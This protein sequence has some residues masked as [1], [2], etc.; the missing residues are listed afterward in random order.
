MP[1]TSRETVASDT[2]SFEVEPIAIIGLACRPPGARDARQ[3]W[4]NLVQGVESVRMETLEEQ[5]ARGVPEAMLRDPNFVP[6]VALV[7]DYEYF[8]AG[9]FGMSAREAQI[10][11]PQHRMFLELSYTA[12]E[13]AG[14]DPFRYPGDIGVYAGCGDAS[15]E[16]QHARR[17]RKVLAGAGNL[18]ISLGT[19]P[20]FLATFISYKLD[21]RGPS[22]TVHT[23]CSTSLVTLHL[24]CEALRN[25]ECDMA[26]S[27]AVSID[28]P[29]GHGYIYVD[30]GIYSPD[31]HVRAF[32]AAARGTI[33]GNGGGMVLLK[34]LC[35]ALAD[36]DHI[37]ALVR[38]NA[39]NN[40]GSA[41][42]G[43]TAPS[44]QAQAVV[45]AQALG[46]ADVDPR[47]ISY[48]EAHGTGTQLG[49]PI[50]IA[51]LT[52]AYGAGTDAVGWCAIGSVKPNVGHMG[53][54][55]GVISIIKTTLALEN[56]LIPPSVNYSAPNPAIDFP[57]TPFYVNS[58]L[59]A[60][61]SNGTPRRAGVSSF[62]MGG[63][64]AHVIMQE[65]PWT[66]RRKPP[67]T[68]TYLLP[69][70]ARSQS[71]LA[72]AAQDL[73]AR[74]S[75]AHVHAASSADDSAAFLDLADVS[76]TLRVGRREHSHRLAVVAS[77]LEQAAAA[78]RDQ[79]RWITAG[80]PAGTGSGR[81]PARLT[82]GKTPRVALMFSGQGAQY[83]GMGSQLYR[84]MPAFRDIVDECADLL[85]SECGLDLRTALL[86]DDAAAGEALKQTALA[87]PALFVIE[88]ALARLW[89]SWGIEP[90]AMIGHSIGEYVA[91]T[92]AGVFEL[93]DALRVVAAR[94]RLMQAIAP[95]AMLA[96]QLG[97]AELQPRLPEDVSI[98][99]INGPATCVVAGPHE[100][101]EA[102]ASQLAG[103]GVGSRPLRTSHAFHSSMMDPVLAEFRAVVADA[104]PRAPARPFVSNV[105]GM[106][107]SPR[108]AADPSFWARH[109]REPVRFG[110][111]LRTLLGDDDEWLLVECGPGR[112]LCGLA[113]LNRASGA[114]PVPSLPHR[115]DRSN[116]A[117]TI[118]AAAALLWASGVALDLPSFAAPGFRVPLPTYPWERKYFWID[119]DPGGSG[120]GMYDD[121]LEHAQERR[122]LPDWF[123]VPAWQQLPPGG[124]RRQPA[125]RVLLFA[126][127][128]AL[129]IA[130]ALTAAGADV[131]VVRPGAAFADEG[132]GRYTIRPQV[133]DDYDSLIEHLK[134]GPGLPAHVV[135]AW[136]LTDH[137]S[138]DPD[139]AW[140]SQDIGFFSLL[141]LVQA[142]AGEQPESGVLIDVLTAGT[143]DVTGTDLR[144]PQHAPVIGVAKVAPLEMPWL[145][146][147][148]LDLDPDSRELK[149]LVDELAREPADG[150]N[151]VTAAG[152]ADDGVTLALRG[153]RRWRR[154]Y[155]P[156]PLGDVAAR[157]SGLRERGV[158]L[159]TG[160]LGGIGITIAQDLA[161][162]VRARLVLVARGGLPP[163]AEWDATLAVR[164]TAD[165]TGRAITAIRRMESAGAEVL[166]VAADVTSTA[167]LAAVRERA[168][169]R[170]GTL[171]GI[172]HAAGTA[173]GGMAEVKD[174]AAAEAVMAPKLVGTLALRQVFGTENLDF[175]VLCSSV[176]AVSGEFGQL[177]YCAANNF[178]DAFARSRHGWNTPVTSVNW[179]SWLEVGMSAEVAA[180]AA[181]R[182]LQRGD[183]LSQLDHPLLTRCYTGA[184]DTPGW[185]S[186]IVSTGTHWLLADHRIGGVPVIPGTGHL[187]AVR[188]AFEAVWSRP[189]PRHVVELRDVSF[190]EPMSLAE[191]A[192][193]ELRVVFTQADGG[194]DFRAV[195]LTGGAQRTHAQGGVA[196]TEPGE[197]ASV[198]LDAVR[199]NCRAVQKAGIDN[200]L[201]STGLITF[202][203]H[204]GNLKEIHC[205]QAEEL[206]L[207][208][209][210]EATAA[211]LARWPLHP[212]LLDEATAF[213]QSGFD[214]Q[215]LPFGY[216]R[217]TIRGPL[218][219]RLWSYLRHRDAGTGEVRSSDIT[220]LDDAGNPIVSI[221]E[222]TT[223]HVDAKALGETMRASGAFASPAA[224][225]PADAA[226]TLVGS[227]QGNG[228]RPAEGAR[229]FR[230][231]LTGD[232]GPQVMVSVLPI[233][234]IIASTREFTKETIENDLD[235]TAL[236]QDPQRSDADGY[237]APRTEL[238]A[239]IARIWGDVLG[240]QIGATDDFFDVGGNSLIAVQLIA[241]V[242][243][244][245]GVRLPMRSI[246]EAPTVAGAAALI[247]S[248]REDD[249]NGQDASARQEPETG[250]IPRL[251]RNTKPAA[252]QTET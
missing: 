87:Q 66:Q 58:V 205:G 177:D 171:N 157:E 207:L 198:D 14:Y 22:L 119:P 219:A 162:R 128:A 79:S 189:S 74:L 173:G 41:K 13:D 52:R 27:G 238:E 3:F 130:D 202:G 75:E 89:H 134:A 31:G 188:A 59:S 101:V 146:M 124:A 69:V 218:P 106:W 42:V 166:V 45:V 54:A 243:K 182:A 65:A 126:D 153:G 110:D 155:V 84:S 96:V 186:G 150:G 47:S 85:R 248:L 211:D 249:Q 4:D 11:D 91:A 158:Y 76:F 17:N 102:F 227:T 99:A 9:F 18:A 147:R 129:S 30:D 224:V 174:R 229:C 34:R 20:D 108:E 78:L 154:R 234:D 28:L 57:A 208:E 60:W 21:L 181:F 190:I 111:G 213:G 117:E 122:P 114:L 2:G 195:S 116:D 131:A 118:T 194:L 29:R 26:L 217:V 228:I 180:P 115:G 120:D 44:E 40:D 148:H 225:P 169:E 38:G 63:T 39:I 105:T 88:Y 43:F 206:A 200:G 32:D 164:G 175:V 7:D 136:T 82:P 247:E 143:Q 222:F 97:E 90:D 203:P 245:I 98:A 71:A 191:G 201:S 107:I 176:Y 23:A 8:D 233:A 196:W 215:F 36:G 10:R 53:A 161:E 62:G 46:V 199:R 242:R 86:A 61:K 133:R 192:A 251:P 19:H 172:V 100:A 239:S 16:W 226:Q 50:E 80:R 141:S 160:G 25:G 216:G 250:T 138:A 77:D 109:V 252:N 221:S 135:H 142:L 104:N 185:C 220:L 246:F 125:G 55:A 73:A 156:A 149:Q 210:T 72:T 231:V 167:E 5:A 132:G 12:L 232:L 121:L 103:D 140:R 168:I 144:C 151:T 184:N 35:D 193:A 241:M 67:E 209:A 49:D 204:W 127:Q 68:G 94:G 152:G 70:S 48:V 230:E 159:I 123:A 240:G 235:A 56:E 170:F 137:W 64:N 113:K 165:R 93:P 92:R 214:S 163:R 212:S 178:M 237:V 33:W 179:G 187:E 24:A 1:S 51:G 236:R 223:R 145:T 83:A 244:E 6:A 183:R 15:Y 112:Q 81:Q 95:G 197:A 139:A 37:R